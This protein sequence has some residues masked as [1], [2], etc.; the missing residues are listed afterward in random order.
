M[1]GIISGIKR[2]EIHDGDGIRTTVFFKGCPLRCIWCHNPESISPQPEVAK[3]EH[4]CVSCGLCGDKR[5]VE[6]ANNCPTGALTA[7][8]EEYEAQRLCDVLARDKAYFDAS[9]GGVTLSGGECLAQPA[10]AAEVARLLH[11]RGISVYVDTCGFVSR[12]SLDAI[13]P[14]T[15]KFLYDIKAIDASVHEKCT[16]RDNKIIL[17]NLEYL[18][19][20][21]CKI[22]IRYPLVKGYNDGECDKIGE[23]LSILGGIDKIK[24]LKYHNFAGSRYEALGKENTLPKTVTERSDIERAVGI[25]N[26]YG[27]CAVNGMDED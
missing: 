10:F 17:E 18:V 2:M 4:K 3:F 16:G 5:T 24:V 21:N 12:T 1:T 19:S 9:G 27:L 20:K 7:Y 11:G 23:L 8:G 13:I 14:Y 6:G 25:L 26:S 15:D 22:E